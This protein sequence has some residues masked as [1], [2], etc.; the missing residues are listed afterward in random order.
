MLDVLGVTMRWLHLSAVVTLIG[1]MLYA[2]L[3]IR[4]AAAALSPD[5]AA[6]LA[7]NAAARFRP[8]VWASVAALILSGTY[9][10]ISTPGHSPLYLLLL[11]LKLLLVLH[12]FASALLAARPRNPRRARQ[13]TGAFLSGLL[14]ILISAY[15]RRIF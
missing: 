5:A 13:M 1:G 9:N 8:L 6:T 12:V 2:S 10:L 3:V 15:L 4:A 7:E 11:G 14:I